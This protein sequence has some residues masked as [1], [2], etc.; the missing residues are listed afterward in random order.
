MFVRVHVIAWMLLL[1]HLSQ[2]G[3]SLTNHRTLGFPDDLCDFNTE[4]IRDSKEMINEL[5]T[6]LSY[7]NCNAGMDEYC[8]H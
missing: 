5:Q 3:E 2:Y 6:V 8:N 1:V 7:Y 4:S